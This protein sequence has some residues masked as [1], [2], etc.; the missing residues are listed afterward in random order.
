MSSTCPPLLTPLAC[1]Q[2]GVGFTL[3]AWS[4][5]H[6]ELH[7]RAGMGANFPVPTAGNS[8]WVDI[9]GCGCCARL[10][11]TGRTGD[12]LT[13]V[14]PAAGDCDCIGS[15][16]RVAYATSSPEHIRALAAEVPFNVQ[17]PLRWDCATR[18]LSI[19]CAALKDLVATPCG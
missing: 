17:P 3:S 14:P 19:D 2:T 10:Q 13:V 11:V 5:P 7:L 1:G 9:G 8:F 18:T 6:T 16:A 4:A 12:V 15:N